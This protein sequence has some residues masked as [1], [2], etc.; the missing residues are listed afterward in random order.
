MEYVTYWLGGF[1]VLGVY[2]IA[3]ADY[4]EG[5][6]ESTKTLARLFWLGL[7]LFAWPLILVCD[8]GCGVRRIVK[9]K[10]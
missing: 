3:S 1:V 6:D 2:G 9:G 8:I 7:C 4:E 10:E 5:T